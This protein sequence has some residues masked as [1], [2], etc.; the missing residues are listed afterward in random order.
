[1]MYRNECWKVEDG[2]VGQQV[3]IPPKSERRTVLSQQQPAGWFLIR[4]RARIFQFS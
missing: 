4:P 3:Y 1:M 2:A